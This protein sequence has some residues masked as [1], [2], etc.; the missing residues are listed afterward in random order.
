[1]PEHGPSRWVAPGHAVSQ[2]WGKLG[3]GLGAPHPIPAHEIGRFQSR[4]R[5][6]SRGVVRSIEDEGLG[7]RAKSLFQLRG[8]KAPVR[9]AQ[10]HKA[11]PCGHRRQGKWPKWLR[12]EALRLTFDK[13]RGPAAVDLLYKFTSLRIVPN[14]IP[15][16]DKTP[17]LWYSASGM[18]SDIFIT[19]L[20]RFALA[21]RFTSGFFWPKAC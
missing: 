13:C 6:I 9:W 16:D 3:S 17:G 15:Q 7:V 2:A 11:Q 4:R 10:L 5:F 18:R 21:F 12:S 20:K 14:K 1:M 8:I 19:Q